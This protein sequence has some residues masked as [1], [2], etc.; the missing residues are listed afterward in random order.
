M[1]NHQEVE[2]F[3]TIR[4]GG[5]VG[6]GV[7]LG[8]GLRFQVCTNPISISACFL[9]IRMKVSATLPLCMLVNTFTTMII[10]DSVP[11]AASQS[12]V[13]RFLL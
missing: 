4:K 7:S 2:M 12:S 5:L 8:Q 3:G 11:E 6:E 9:Q 10:M 1:V 13:K